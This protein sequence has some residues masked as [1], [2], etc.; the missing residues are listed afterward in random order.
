MTAATTTQQPPALCSRCREASSPW[1]IP[2]SATPRM[3][4]CRHA[5]LLL[6]LDLCPAAVTAGLPYPVTGCLSC[7]AETVIACTYYL[8]SVQHCTEFQHACTLDVIF[9][10]PSVHTGA[11]LCCLG[12]I[13]SILG[14]QAGIH[15]VVATAHPAGVGP[16]SLFS[17]I[18]SKAWREE[19][20]SS[21]C[22]LHP[23]FADLHTPWSGG[24]G[25]ELQPQ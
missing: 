14:T 8:A 11:C 10:L 6:G 2:S 19:V 13:A 23:I 4:R 1:R 20:S 24:G 5:T 25:R 18:L 12:F 7:L 16:P 15:C 9:V 22:N 17:I 3:S 21:F